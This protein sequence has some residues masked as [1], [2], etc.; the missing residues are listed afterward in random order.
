VDMPTEKTEERKS[1]RRFVVTGVNPEGTKIY[2]WKTFDA[3]EPPTEAELPSK[4]GKGEV[5]IVEGSETESSHSPQFPSVD[6]KRM[7]RDFD[8]AGAPTKG[9]K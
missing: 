4:D 9:A 8:A 6:S 3:G 5:T 7:A 1:V 2:G